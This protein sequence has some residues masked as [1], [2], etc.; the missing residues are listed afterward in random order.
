MVPNSFHAIAKG[1]GGTSPQSIPVSVTL[2][3]TVPQAPSG[4]SAQPLKQGKIQ[5]SWNSVT[6]TGPVTYNL[7]RATVSFENVSQAT[8]INAAPLQNTI[9]TDQPGQDKTY[10]YRVIA[11]NEAGSVSA[12]FATSRCKCR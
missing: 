12:P 11:M 1:K 6:S 3:K 4:I 9:F 8:K 5:L 10:Y 2:D 7:Y